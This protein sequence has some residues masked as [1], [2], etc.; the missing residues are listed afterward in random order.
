[1]YFVCF[2][3][4]IIFHRRE[5]VERGGKRFDGNLNLSSLIETVDKR[6]MVY[7]IQFGHIK[8]QQA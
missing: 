1:M 4:K 5:E 6:K 2:F 7:A 8:S 3:L